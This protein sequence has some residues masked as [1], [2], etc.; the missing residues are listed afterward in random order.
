MVRNLLCLILFFI[1]LPFSYGQ[2]YAGKDFWVTFL[3][4]DVN[5]DP[6]PFLPPIPLWSDD[7]LELYLLSPTKAKVTVQASKNYPIGS[8]INFNYSKTIILIPN[9]YYYLRLPS[10]LACHTLLSGIKTNNGVHVTADTFINVTAVTR[11]NNFKGATTVIPSESIPNNPEYFVTTNQ[12]NN[13][14]SCYSNIMHKDAKSPEFAI[15]GIAD[16][17]VIEVVPTGVSTT[18]NNIR[19]MPFLIVLKKGETYGYVSTDDD[20][21]GSILRSRD[22]SSKFA[23]FAGNRLTNSYQINSIGNLCKGFTD[24]TYEQMIPTVNWGNAYTA[25]PFKNNTGYFLKIVAAENNTYIKINGYIN[26]ILQQGENFVFN[27]PK[28]SATKVDADKRISVMQ[29]AKGNGCDNHP[30]P[31]TNVGGISEIQLIA[32]VQ[33]YQK[34]NINAL[35]NDAYGK[36]AEH[37]FNVLVKTKD[38][39]F[40]KYNGKGVL[41]SLWKSAPQLNGYSYFQLQMDTTCYQLSSTKGFL[42]YNYGYGIFNGY[43]SA[44]AANFKSIQNNFFLDA[45]C[46]SELITF[47]GVQT[48]SFNNYSWRFSDNSSASGRV[49]KKTFKDTGWFIATMY[50][51]QLR[52][53]AIDSV[54][55]KIYIAASGIGPVLIKDT[56]ICGRVNF[57]VY[58]K[59]FDPDFTYLWNDGHPNYY[60]AI[61]APGQYW[62]K[63]IQSN[64]CVYVDTLNV[65]SYPLPKATFSVSDSILCF[66]RNKSIKFTNLSTSI[67]SIVSNQWN[68]VEAKYTDS[69]KFIIHQF[70]QVGKYLTHLTV[71]TNKGCTHDTTQLIRILQPPKANFIISDTVQCEK[72]NLFQSIDS[73]SSDSGQLISKQWIYSDGTRLQDKDSGLKHFSTAGFKIISIKVNNSQGCSD[74]T[75][76]KIEV[77]ANPQVDFSVNQI[78]QCYNAQIFTFTYLPKITNDSIKRYTWY[79]NN[80]SIKN[81]LSINAFKFPLSASYPV[82]LKLFSVNDCEGELQK[83]VFVNLMPQANISVND[84]EQCFNGQNFNFTNTS[85]ISKGNLFSHNWDF[86]DATNSVLKNPPAKVYGNSGAFKLLYTVSSD[87]GCLDSASVSIRVYDNAIINS[88]N[89]NGACL[90]DSVLF[91]GNA[92]IAKGSFISSWDFGDGSTGTGNLTRHLYQNIGTYQAYYKTVSDHNCRD[93]NL[94]NVKIVNNPK[95]DFVFVHYNRDNSG[96][97]FLFLDRSEGG[98]NWQWQFGNLGNS[99][100]QDPDYYFTDTGSVNVRLVISNQNLCYDT[101]VKHIPILEKIAFYF[102]NAFTPNGNGLNDGFG[103]NPN[104]F[105]LVKDYRLQVFNRW[106]E[107]LFDNENKEEHWL[108]PDDTNILQGVYIYKATI[109]DIYNV[110]HNIKGVVEVIR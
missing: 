64:G 33:F 60:K 86:G 37:Y 28:D 12:S 56:A 23:V 41:N 59:G 42:A 103:L 106:G 1:G 107:K 105:E 96:I 58:S 110:Y 6:P 67:D 13:T 26:K 21:T 99:N 16:Q 75:G 22:A 15:V 70:A 10:E 84:S 31:K 72:N 108:I 50:T 19:G 104:Q 40:F 80:D 109:R 63:I 77:K 8:G 51:H 101:I 53:N 55:K 68:L 69:S 65:I 94:V 88:A 76:R 29:F 34:A 43:A 24:H 91:S 11:Y 97:R 95:A 83:N 5:C 81:Q 74:S 2:G 52:T 46:K 14:W 18:K 102:P 38:T 89:A 82:Q 7:T 30:A 93:S 9:Q 73:S 17:S 61:K 92:N 4:P 45:Q 98:N 3:E 49:I 27:V 100:L 25:L 57:A 39:S 62:E 47:T 48:D 32:D 87:S 78:S 90:N 71:K 20:L 54:V 44:V 36:V 35:M 85:T 66:N 79:F